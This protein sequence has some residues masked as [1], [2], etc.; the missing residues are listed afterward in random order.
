[1][2]LR[3]GKALLYG[4]MAGG[5][6]TSRF[7]LSQGS[8][9]KDLGKGSTI[10]V[11]ASDLHEEAPIWWLRLK[12]AATRG[13]TLIVASARPPRLDRYAAHVLRYRYGQEADLV[14][15]LLP[16]AASGNALAEREDVRLAAQAFAGAENAIV[17]YGQEGLGLEGSA[18][19]AQACARLL[20]STGHTGK[21]NN[22]LVAVWP[23]ANTQGAW[24]MGFRP[25]AD[26]KAALA[27]AGVAYIAAAD[28]AGDDPALA[29]ALSS[30]GFVVVQELFL[31]E[32]A[33]LAD[34][35]LPAQSFAEREGSFTSGER[36][37]QRFYPAIKP[38]K[39]ARPDYAITGQLAVRLK[40]ELEA[41]S[42]ARLMDQIAA[43][44]PDYAGV[45]YARLAEASVQTPRIG[46]QSLYYG[47]TS[48]DNQ[49]G[50]GVQLPLEASGQPDLEA[51]PDVGIVASAAVDGLLAVPVTRLYDQGQTLQASDFLLGSR[52]A[53]SLVQ[54]CPDE[55]ARFGVA[56]GD[57]ALIRLDGI[58]RTV[59]IA[60]SEDVPEGLLLA[61]RSSGLG[62][63]APTPVELVSLAVLEKG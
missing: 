13:A 35:V 27:Q 52:I 57:Q 10:L 54:I 30:A 21:A 28:P 43:E 45:S 50:L 22:G 49:Q 24:D 47:G 12:Q 48:Y 59:R 14:A 55:A 40:L 56:A 37:V 15:A 51:L 8:N 62:I 5:D 29:Q 36:R 20:E 60:L 33:R 31:T 53:G 26:L 1:T 3:G 25:A 11:V 42:G 19:L 2:A 18:R 63:T 41:R 23:Q 38:F 6:L 32:T 61:P 4:E 44:A 9:L 58:E 17:F 16:E 39:E 46:R 7:G 34:V